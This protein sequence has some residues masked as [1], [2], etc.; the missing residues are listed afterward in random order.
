MTFDNC[1]GIIQVEGG[2]SVCMNIKMIENEYWWGLSAS[3][4][5]KMPFSK[6]TDL[7]VDLGDRGT[8]NQ[9]MPLLVSSKG[10]YIW[11]ENPFCVTFKDGEIT[12]EG[13]EIILDESGK[14]LKD[15]YL[16]AS[17]NHFPFDNA[18]LAH[19]FFETAQ[20]NGWMQFTYNPTQEKVLEYAHGIVDNGFEPGILI[21]DEGWHQPYGTWDFDKIKFPDPAKMVE[22]LHNLGFKVMLWVCPFVRNDGEQYVKSMR[23]GAEFGESKISTELYLRT[24]E[25]VWYSPAI[26]Q[27]WNGYSAILDFTKEADNNFLKIQLDALM[28]NYKIDGFKFDGGSW[29]YYSDL[30]CKNGHILEEE[31][32]YLRNIAWNEFGR[33]YKY[34]EYKDSYKCGGKCS[35]SRLADRAHSWDKNGLNTII[36]NTIAQGLIGHPFVCPDMI[37]GGEWSMFLRDGFVF[38]EELFVRMAQ[39]STYLPMMQF[40]LAPWEYL[41]E[42]NC[43]YCLDAA[44][45]HKEIAP[46]I[47]RLV[48]ESRRSGEPIVKPMAYEFPEENYETV[49]DYFIFGKNTLVAPVLEKGHITKTVR[50][51]KGFNWEYID[52]SIYHGGETVTVSAPISVLPVFTKIEI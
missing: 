7:T 2:L 9:I 21:I 37:G 18:E 41:N 20:Y 12:L 36:P 48:N 45:K 46:E 30:C 35:I 29:P 22:E 25:E 32:K 19:E 51:P 17:K 52:G 28:E 27:W 40:S 49:K 3:L 16:N 33:A 14:N 8:S 5:V 26:V 13:E 4:G 34:H 47:I 23:Y 24:D 6:E 43:S 10:R 11:S 1:N 39:A 42:E 15:A 50:L 38:D 31:K 44:K